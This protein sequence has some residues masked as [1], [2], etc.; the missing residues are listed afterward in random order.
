MPLLSFVPKAF[1]S[2]TNFANSVTDAVTP[3]EN[4]QS[5]YEYYLD[6][7]GKWPTSIALASQWMVTIHFDKVTNLFSNIQDKLISRE[8][9]VWR[10]N[11][12]VIDVLIDGG[13]QAKSDN[14]SGCVFARQVVLPSERIEAGN[15]G[16]E[17]GGFLPPSTA[18][19]RDPYEPLSITML[20][21]NASFLDLVI[22]PWI[23]MV[24]YNGLIARSPR[25]EKNVKAMIDV[26]MY[27]KTGYGY[28]M[29]I[30]KI[31]RFYNAAPISLAG[32]TYS[33]N[34]EGLRYS[35]VK[36]TYDKYCVLDGNSSTFV[37]LD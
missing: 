28:P 8:Q 4:S 33:Y 35:D 2:I 12:A 1:D 14:M 25:S 15:V 22:R 6:L 10:Y 11:N 18:G 36:F 31:Y 30:R 19:K 21:T 3:Y 7:L 32:E 24:G 20:E 9:S 5:P 29:G 26:V 16:L 27:A 13:L 37:F 23:I 34:E 17:Y